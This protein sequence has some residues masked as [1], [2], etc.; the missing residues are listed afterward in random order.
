[1]IHR[2]SL[3]ERLRGQTRNLLGSACA[4]SSPAGCAF[5]LGCSLPLRLSSTP[6]HALTPADSHHGPRQR[7]CGWPCCACGSSL[8]VKDL[9]R[10]AVCAKAKSTSNASRVG[11]E[12]TRAEPIGFQVQPLNHSGNVNAKY[13]QDVRISSQGRK[14]PV[15][16]SLPHRLL[17]H[18]RCRHEPA[19]TCGEQHFRRSDPH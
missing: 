8:C 13:G 15:L 12:P 17:F 18:F 14:P 16:R 5:L 10:Q 7:P 11:F 2:A 1:M 4:G 19:H 3:P 9:C 6:R